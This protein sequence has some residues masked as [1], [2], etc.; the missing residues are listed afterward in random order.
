MST[1]RLGAGDSA[2][3]S[4]IFDAKADF[5]VATAADTPARLAVGTTNG[6]F[7]KVDS[8]TATGLAWGSVG[9]V[10]QVVSSTITTSTAI[11]SQSLTDTN[12]TASITPTSATSKILV[13][14]AVHRK[15][16]R[17]SSSAIT[18]HSLLRGSTSLI[19]WGNNSGFGIE[20]TGATVVQIIDQAPI[21]YLDSPATTSSTTYKVQARVETVGETVTYQFGSKP[22]TITLIEIGA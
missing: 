11:T 15:A 5:L 4:T 1:G 20:A 17:S 21:I 3:Q 7:L 19:D 10:L 9:N 2:I 22:S 18:G 16:S 6:Q 12:I 14:I 8:S 13:I